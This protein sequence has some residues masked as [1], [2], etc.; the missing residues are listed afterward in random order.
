MA[1]VSEILLV[2]FSTSRVGHW[3]AKY[4]LYFEEHLWLFFLGYLGF[5]V[6]NT[7]VFYGNF[8]LKLRL[9][10]HSHDLQMDLRFSMDISG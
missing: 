6:D 5:C 7:T 10:S 3:N 9:C 2:F 8:G 1:L 4:S